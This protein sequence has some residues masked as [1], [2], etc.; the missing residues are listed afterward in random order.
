MITCE[1]MGGLGNQ[2]FQIFTTIAYALDNNDR[3]VFLY[4]KMFG[5]RPSYWDNF[6]L[7]LKKYTFP[8]RIQASVLREKAFHYDE[9]QKKNE[10]ENISLYGYFQSE[11]YFKKH[12]SQIAELAMNLTE[13]KESIIKE[14]FQKMNQLNTISMHFRI[15]DYMNL[16]DC[17][18]VLIPIYYKNSIEKIIE[19]TNN[20]EWTI[21]FFCEEDDIDYVNKEYIQ[22]L[23]NEFPK[24]KFIR[25][26]PKISDWEQMIF[27]SC[28]EHHIIANSTF[29]WWGAYLHFSKDKL[30]CWPSVW[31]GPRL[32]END[33]KDII[34]E[35]DNWIQVS[36][37]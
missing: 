3:F 4:S 9:L 10:N 25:A 7:P 11:K 28:C 27:M 14:E 13:L 32:A 2:L 22:L 26:N 33:I 5:K 17:H 16:Q 8:N 21:I 35:D 1:L 19:K 18:P 36:A 23:E 31:F 20:F 29:S 37:M 6:L 30:V 24:C 15:G 12:S 34:P